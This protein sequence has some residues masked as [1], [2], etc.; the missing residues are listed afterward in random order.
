[1]SGML[2]VGAK[3]PA[4][5]SVMVSK[6]ENDK[7]MPMFDICPDCGFAYGCGGIHKDFD[8]PDKIVEYALSICG[9][10]TMADLRAAV[11]AGSVGLAVDNPASAMPQVDKWSRNEA[12][13]WRY[14]GS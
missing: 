12:V 7:N 10:N 14:T 5:D 6:W 4:C 11:A 8:T 9:C 1:M 2:F 13:K 3:C